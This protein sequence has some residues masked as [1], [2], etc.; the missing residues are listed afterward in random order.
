MAEQVVDWKRRDVMFYSFS[1]LKNKMVA[2]DLNHLWTCYQMTHDVAYQMTHE[3]S[4]S[5]SYSY[6]QTIVEI[7]FIK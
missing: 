7:L 6:V 3:V 1:E 5:I 4:I 2:D